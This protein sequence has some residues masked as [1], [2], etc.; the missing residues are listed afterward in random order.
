MAETRPAENEIANLK[1]TYLNSMWLKSK[2]RLSQRKMRS[3]F[4]P[5]I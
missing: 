1:G 5:E 3:M 2:L 4:S